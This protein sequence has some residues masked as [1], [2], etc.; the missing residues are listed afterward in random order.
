MVTFI[1]DDLTILGNPIIHNS[2]AVEALH[3]GNI[4]ETSWLTLATPKLSNLLFVD[5]EERR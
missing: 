2:L 3:Q 5:A 4:N 1:H